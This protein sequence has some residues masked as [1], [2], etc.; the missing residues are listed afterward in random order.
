MYIKGH[1]NV[2][3]PI[4]PYQVFV[5]YE[6]V[7]ERSTSNNAQVIPVSFITQLL[8]FNFLKNIEFQSCYLHS[9]Y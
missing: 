9:I 2:N 8:V 1:I 3:L 6:I 7:I 5:C 4:L